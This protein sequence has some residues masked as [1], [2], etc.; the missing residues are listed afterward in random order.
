MV[1]NAFQ[2]ALSN[3]SQLLLMGYLNAKVVLH[4]V[5]IVR[6]LQS[7]LNVHHRWYY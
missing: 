7:A 5:I 4:H 3:T 2:P 1:L 6:T